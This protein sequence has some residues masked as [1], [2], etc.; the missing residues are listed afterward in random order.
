MITPRLKREDEVGGILE[1]PG[2]HRDFIEGRSKVNQIKVYDDVR[3]DW[4][5][6]ID[7]DDLAADE[8][9][10][11]AA[12]MTRKL[13]RLAD[14]DNACCERIHR[15]PIIVCALQE[16]KRRF[17]KDSEAVA[18]AIKVFT[19]LKTW[20]KTELDDDNRPET[21]RAEKVFRSDI[22]DD[23]VEDPAVTDIAVRV[24]LVMS[25]VC[26][27]SRHDVSTTIRPAT[28]AARLNGVSL[29][30]VKRAKRNLINAGWAKI[31]HVKGKP[32]EMILFEV[33][34]VQNLDKK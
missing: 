34:S 29:S 24:Y 5:D 13:F 8:I 10:K 6:F 25:K 11:T 28:I 32:D 16:L 9:I 3:D 12:R 19:P 31:K 23:L 20:K 21:Y 18:E 33:K 15:K 17:G 4:N 14:I 30:T 27:N 7:A 2:S 1:E 26:P 22:P